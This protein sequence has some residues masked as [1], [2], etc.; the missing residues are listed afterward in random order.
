MWRVRSLEKM[1]EVE[2][3]V[4]DGREME[5]IVMGRRLRCP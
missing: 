3:S 1:I 5:K 2:T 4:G